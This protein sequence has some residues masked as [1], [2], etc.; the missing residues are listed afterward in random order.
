M[1]PQ[2]QYIQNPSLNVCSEK[3]YLK[4]SHYR[5]LPDSGEL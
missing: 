4:Y 3:H 2:H 1:E 5:V